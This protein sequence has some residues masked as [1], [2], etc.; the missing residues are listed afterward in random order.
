[1]LAIIFIYSVLKTRS[2]WAQFWFSSSFPCIALAEP[3]NHC[4]HPPYPSFLCTAYS[5]MNKHVISVCISLPG[6]RL[7]RQQFLLHCWYIYFFLIVILIISKGGKKTI[8]KYIPYCQEL[9]IW[10]RKEDM[11]CIH[12]GSTKKLNVL[13]SLA[14]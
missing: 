7:P 10:K 5:Q 14:L 2:S 11:L 12:N 8:H 4:L 1:M 13:L 6:I 9:M 3:V